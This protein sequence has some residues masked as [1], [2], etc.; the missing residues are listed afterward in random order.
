MNERSV[1]ARHELL[2]A[3]VDRFPNLL[4]DRIPDAQRTVGRVT[5]KMVAS[6]PP[7]M[8][9]D[10]PV[11]VCYTTRGLAFWRGAA[12]QVIHQQRRAGR[13][14]GFKHG[15]IAVYPAIQFRDTDSAL[16]VEK[17]LLAQRLNP[18]ID[19]VAVAVRPPNTERESR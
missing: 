19:A 6:L 18:L 3:L 12:R 2:E 9:E 10:P 17:E 14:M 8:I 5:E 15:R 11:G 16:P 4:W 13:I 1:T 7:A